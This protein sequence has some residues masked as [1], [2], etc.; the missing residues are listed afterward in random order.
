MSQPRLALLLLVA[1]TC[2]SFAQQSTPPASHSD[3][4]W[5]V[6]RSSNL[7]PHFESRNGRQLLY[8]DGSPFI[9]LAAEIPRWDLIYGRYKETEVAYDNLYPA[10]EKIGL[11]T[12]KVPVKCRWSSRKKVPTT[13][14]GSEESYGRDKV[15]VFAGF[16]F[17]LD[18]LVARVEFLL[19]FV[20]KRRGSGANAQRDFTLN[21]VP[22]ASWQGRVNRI[23][24]PD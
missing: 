4:V 20:P 10:A 17:E 22:S 8:V 14:R 11:N 15:N 12:L 3:D 7:I 24:I 13:R 23:P 9:A 5:Q 6:A 18:A 1:W 2:A 19:Y 21:F 16:D